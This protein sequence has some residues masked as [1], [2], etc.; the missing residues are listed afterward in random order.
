MPRMRRAVDGKVLKGTIDFVWC[1]NRSSRPRMS[2]L[3]CE[4]CSHREKCV[5]FKTFKKE[6][7]DLYPEEQD[8]KKPARKKAKEVK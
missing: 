6:R 4:R 8:L 7:P 1:H 3:I 2:Y 5:D